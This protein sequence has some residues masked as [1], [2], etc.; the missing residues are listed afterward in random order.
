[1][2]FNKPFE[3]VLDHDGKQYT[4]PDTDEDWIEILLN[5]ELL[6]CDEVFEVWHFEGKVIFTANELEEIFS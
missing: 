5:G 4:Q 1:M 2:R 3:G 6:F